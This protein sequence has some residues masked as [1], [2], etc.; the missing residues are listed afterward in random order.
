MKIEISLS[1]PLKWEER[2]LTFNKVR[3]KIWFYGLI[4]QIY[5]KRSHITNHDDHIYRLIIITNIVIINYRVKFLSSSCRLEQEH[6]L[7]GS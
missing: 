6:V 5:T 7:N 1:T 3:S 2:S 4:L